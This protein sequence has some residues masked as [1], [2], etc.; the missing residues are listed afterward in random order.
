MQSLLLTAATN[1]HVLVLICDD[2][3]GD[4]NQCNTPHLP[5]CSPPKLGRKENGPPRSHTPKG[6]K[7]VFD[8]QLTV[9]SSGKRERAQVHQN[10]KRPSVRKGQDL[11]TNPEQSRPVEKEPACV[12]L[13]KQEG[14]FLHNS[15]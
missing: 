1:D 12:G 9:Q 5:P 8:N 7:L 13:F 2:I 10:K 4:D 15:C 6:R 3:I 11:T 14:L